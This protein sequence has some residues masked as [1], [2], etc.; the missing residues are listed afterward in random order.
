[1]CDDYDTSYFSATYDTILLSMICG[2]LICV[3]NAIK[4]STCIYIDILRVHNDWREERGSLDPLGGVVKM[5]E[6]NAWR[7]SE[8]TS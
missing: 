7:E 4:V 3:S 5:R 2:L 1:M 8:R 6:N